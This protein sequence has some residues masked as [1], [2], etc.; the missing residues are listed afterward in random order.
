M[1]VRSS[2]EALTDL[3]LAMRSYFKFS[4]VNYIGISFCSLSFFLCTVHTPCASSYLLIHPYWRGILGRTFWL[5][6]TVFRCTAFFSTIHKTQNIRHFNWNDSSISL[7]VFSGMNQLFPQ[8]STE[9][10]S[11]LRTCWT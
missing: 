7:I 1:W 10:T 4:L 9:L 2:Q 11:S 8:C 3:Y 5:V 6:L